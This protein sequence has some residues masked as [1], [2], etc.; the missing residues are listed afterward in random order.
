MNKDMVKALI[1]TAGGAVLLAFKP[2]IASIVSTG[3]SLL[4]LGLELQQLLATRSPETKRAL[5]RVR[6][7]VRNDLT[8]W[9]KTEGV[10]AAAEISAADARLAA[11][12]PGIILA[13]DSL[14]AAA[15]EPGGFVRAGAMM[16]VS[17][18]ARADPLFQERSGNIARQYATAVVT[19]ALRAV[20]TERRYFEA[21]QPHL[22]LQLA[23]TVGE[24][25]RKVTRVLAAIEASGATG[26][27]SRAEVQSL[28]RA[29]FE[30]RV[31]EEAARDLLLEKAK[32]L[33][34]LRVRLSEID[35]ADAAL[36]Q[37][38]SH[39]ASAISEGHY[40]EADAI[41]SRLIEEGGSSVLRTLSTT[42]E[43]LWRRAELAHAQTKYYAAAVLYGRA[44]GVALAFDTHLAWH[45]L[46]EQAG[47][48]MEHALKTPGTMH[49][50]SAIAI[51]CKR[52]EM[53]PRGGSDRAASVGQ[54]IT[55]V[56]LYSER[57]DNC[58]GREAV[59]IA[60]K[61]GRDVLEE[62]DPAHDGELM[63]KMANLFGALLNSAVATGI[64]V[65]QKNAR[66]EAVETLT[67]ACELATKHAPTEL[68]NIRTN[69]ATALRRK[70]GRQ[71][72]RS[73]RAQFF[74]RRLRTGFW[75][76]PKHT[77]MTFAISRTPTNPSEM[78]TMLW[79]S[80]E[81]SQIGK[82]FFGH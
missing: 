54:L 61:L 20:L 14:A 77:P 3:S 25:D 62:L 73:N 80:P 12:L 8:A 4:S 46:G 68:R 50:E 41:L 53:A 24:I 65:G 18:L 26:G 72:N 78:T 44:V 31:P 40:P 81:T 47:S 63:A 9:S 32:E 34:A 57:A 49:Y 60:L 43:L 51:A 56:G 59:S 76:L 7:A 16:I 37:G 75:R 17:E 67:Q 45:L 52:I 21:L 2:D 6:K 29:F 74:G 55:I 10:Q 30:E 11:V 19:S 5:A 36:R 79:S 22:A 42:V 66:E 1:G 35:S 28:L 48:L 82:Y 71:T 33:R 13:R 39:V 23:Q 64:E 70:A 27:L 58:R 15:F 69:L 38:L